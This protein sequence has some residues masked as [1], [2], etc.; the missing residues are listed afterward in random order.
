MNYGWNELQKKL[1][2]DGVK[3]HSFMMALQNEKLTYV[4]PWSE[5]LSTDIKNAIIN[6]CRNN[7]WYFLR[8]CVKIKCGNRYELYRLNP[9]TAAFFYLYTKNIN[10]IMIGT[11]QKSGKTTALG[12]L[13]AYSLFLDGDFFETFLSTRLGKPDSMILLPDYILDAVKKSVSGPS[14]TKHVFLVDEIMHREGSVIGV[15]LYKS[16][17]SITTFF[18]AAT[19]IGK[20]NAD[21]IVRNTIEF[22]TKFYDKNLDALKSSYEETTG[23]GLTMRI[24]Y[25]VDAYFDSDEECKGFCRDMHGYMCADEMMHE[26]YC[27]PNYSIY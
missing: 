13:D 25:P 27:K 10:A 14:N 22:D 4:D 5:K 20:R 17:K 16:S 9:E 1:Q 18:G 24:N 2:E 19:T 21:V 15:D 11:R 23:Y 12:L 8:E 3:N 26:I 6:E 7:I